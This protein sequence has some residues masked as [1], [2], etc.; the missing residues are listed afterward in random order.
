MIKGGGGAMTREKIVARESKRRVYIV[1]E[2]K[3]VSR[4][5]ETR[6]LPIEV[7]EFALEAVV[8]RLTHL[9]LSCVVRSE[10]DRPMRTDNGNLIVD[11]T[12]GSSED[13][14]RLAESLD[15]ISGVVEHGLFLSEA[16]EV[17]VEHAD[18][19]VDRRER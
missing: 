12:M 10:G 2:R 1:D 6:P 18:G 11:A 15:R 14:E 5:G 7:V 9:G 3:L 19:S 17:L 13:P 4:L 16:D 8:R